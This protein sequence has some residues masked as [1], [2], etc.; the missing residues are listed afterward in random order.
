[1]IMNSHDS[2]TAFTNKKNLCNRLL[3][4]LTGGMSKVFP[5]SSQ[6]GKELQRG[7]E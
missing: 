5:Y 6:E 1:M 4:N 2:V 3:S 7:R